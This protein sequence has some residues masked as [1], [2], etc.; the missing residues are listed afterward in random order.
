VP[1][2]TRGKA[3]LEQELNAY[4][5]WGKREKVPLFLGEFGAI[6]AAFAEDRGGERW[7]ADMLR[8]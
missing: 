3:F 1:V 2:Q 5:A 4:L 7:T 8:R 6:R